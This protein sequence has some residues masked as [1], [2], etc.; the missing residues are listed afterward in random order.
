MPAARVTEGDVRDRI[1][2]YIMMQDE[3]ARPTT[4]EEMDRYVEGVWKEI[5][6][7]G[8]V[9]NF[10]LLEKVERLIENE[11]NRQQQAAKKQKT[12]EQGPVTEKLEYKKMSKNNLVKMVVA[13]YREIMV[14]TLSSVPEELWN[15]PEVTVDDEEYYMER[16]AGIMFR[17]I[18]AQGW[19]TLP[20]VRQARLFAR[21]VQAFTTGLKLEIVKNLNELDAAAASRNWDEFKKLLRVA[22]NGAEILAQDLIIRALGKLPPGSQ[23]R[24]EGEMEGVGSALYTQYDRLLE[25]RGEFDDGIFNPNRRLQPQGGEAPA[26]PPAPPARPPA[27]PPPPPPPVPPPVDGPV[28]QD[29]GVGGLDCG[30]FPLQI[31]QKFVEATDELNTFRA[32]KLRIDAEIWLSDP[33]EQ[34]QMGFSAPRGDALVESAAD[35][36]QPAVDDATDKFSGPKFSKDDKARRMPGTGP[37]NTARLLPLDGD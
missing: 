18:G 10:D 29:P 34:A 12:E 28:A 9:A 15:V 2:E 31:S 17:E 25:M 13:R 37:E 5:G 3:D 11:I 20:E 7:G 35:V 21:M 24:Y 26:A 4:E 8:L 23:D 14:V 36:L 27:P 19:Y 30:N 32:D 22:R 6:G 16:F 33:N 1:R